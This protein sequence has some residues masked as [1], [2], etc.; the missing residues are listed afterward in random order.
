M[1]RLRLRV[2]TEATDPVIK[3]IDCNEQDIKPVS[4]R[5]CSL[6]IRWQRKSGSPG[7]KGS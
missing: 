5:R 3:I 4:L 1:W 6:N 2:A 7:A